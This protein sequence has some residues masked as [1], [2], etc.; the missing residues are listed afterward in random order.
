[1]EKFSLNTS[2]LH[3]EILVHLLR[4]IR[5]N[6]N[7]GLRYY[8]KIEDAPLSELLRQAII[9]NYNQL[10]VFYDSICQECIDTGIITGEYFVFYQGGPIDNFTQVP[11]PVAQSSAE[12]DYNSA[13]TAGMALSKSRIL[14]I[15][16]LNKDKNV[17]P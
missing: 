10:M 5:D 6:K 4:Y 2:K 17:V 15:E 12:S 7:L 9:N 11:G 13:C 3:F 8:S 16:F 14:N 1:M